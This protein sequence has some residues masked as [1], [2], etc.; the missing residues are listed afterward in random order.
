MA[1]HPHF[2]WADLFRRDKANQKSVI[3]ILKENT[4]FCT[5][6][7]KELSYLGSLVY[8]RVYQPEE[9]IFRQND[10]GLGVYIITKGRVSVKTQTSQ[11]EVLVTTLSEG[12]FFGEIALVDPENVRTASVVATERSVIIGFFKP[13]LMEILERKPAL[14]VK[15]L[16]Q[17]STVLGRRLLE[18]TEKITQLAR[19]RQVIGKNDPQTK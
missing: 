1:S 19:T 5:L 7:P 3:N 15:I 8:E 16:F 17:L 6:T 10:R 4:L 18:T 12:S 14:G 9:P 11:G 2:L 13:D